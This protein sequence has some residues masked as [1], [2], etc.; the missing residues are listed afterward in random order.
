MNTTDLPDPRGA[1][2]VG[3]WR[4]AADGRVRR[5]EGHSRHVER[6]ASD[7]DITITII[8]SQYDDGRVERLIRVAGLD[9]PDL[10]SIG[11][12][13]ELARTLFNACDEALY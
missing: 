13:R 2:H 8:G 5:F 10:L 9:D 1:V 11:E 3:E 7:T 4:D 6:P 12:T